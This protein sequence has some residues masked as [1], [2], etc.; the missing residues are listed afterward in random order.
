MSV[1][2]E[3]SGRSALVTDLLVVDGQVRGEAA[4]QRERV[5][6]RCPS[7]ER[8]RREFGASGLLRNGAGTA[9]APWSTLREE[10][11]PVSLPKRL[12]QQKRRNATVHK[13][14]M[15]AHPPPD[16]PHRMHLA[17]SAVQEHAAGGE[18][19]ALG[20]LPFVQQSDDSVVAMRLRSLA[21]P[22]FVCRRGGDTGARGQLHNP[23]RLGGRSLRRRVDGHGA[24]PVEPARRARMHCELGSLETP[25]QRP[26]HAQ[27]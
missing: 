22:I 7:V 14:R 21:R 11:S 6:E 1:P 13:S 27:Q 4:G 26:E 23:R 9:H 2:H 20:R 25:K 18:E 10:P 5:S 3:C 8:W 15:A 17:R 12:V 24:C 16:G 19:H